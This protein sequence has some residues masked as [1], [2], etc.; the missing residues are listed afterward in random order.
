MKFLVVDDH[1]LIRQ[2]MHGVLKKLKRDAVIV[3][4][5]TWEA[6]RVA[7]NNHPDINLVILDLTLPDHD[8][9]E[10]LAQLRES[11]PAI[12]VVVVSAVQD[13][14]NVMKALDMGALG[15]IPKSAEADVMLGALRLVLSGSIYIPPAILVRDD[16]SAVTPS[17]STSDRGRAIQLTERQLDVLA[18]VMEGKN[19]KKICR[20][21]N[22]S[23]PTV[24]KHVTKILKALNV[25]NR[26]EAAIAANE[27]GLKRLVLAKE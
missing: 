3:E 24:K 9:F 27:L 19:N 13:R 25:T 8:G 4:A 18:L 5:P 7:L 15:Y 12:S 1:V 23:E 2:A 22:M 11:Y 17:P 21:L 20:A 10:A 6:A 16:A 26:T 14:A